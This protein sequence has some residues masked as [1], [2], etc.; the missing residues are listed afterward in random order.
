MVLTSMEEKI[1]Y[2]SS[3]TQNCTATGI[4]AGREIDGRKGERDGNTGT[5]EK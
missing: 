2:A 1:K 4:Q 5:R 3:Q